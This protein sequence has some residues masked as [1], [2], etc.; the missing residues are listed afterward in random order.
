[1][2]TASLMAIIPYTEHVRRVRSR[3]AAACTARVECSTLALSRSALPK[4]NRSMK[5]P[6][7]NKENADQAEVEEAVARAK[8]LRLQSIQALV[9]GEK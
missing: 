1:M 2:C 5:R 8:N 3:I 7:A 6:R 4:R 9:E